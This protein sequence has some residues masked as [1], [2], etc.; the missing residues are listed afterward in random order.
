M[1]FRFVVCPSPL[2][3]C[4]LWAVFSALSAVSM[5]VCVW[6]GVCGVVCVVR[7]VHFK[8]QHIESRESNK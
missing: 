8:F 7:R 6:C 4:A 1:S 5:V 2:P 3:L